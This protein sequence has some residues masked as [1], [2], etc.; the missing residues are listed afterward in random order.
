MPDTATED[1]L[2]LTAGRCGFRTPDGDHCEGEHRYE[3]PLPDGL[4]LRLTC[5]REGCHAETVVPREIV[6]EYRED[7]DA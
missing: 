5:T 4:T 2:R 3:G 6:G 7:A 1:V